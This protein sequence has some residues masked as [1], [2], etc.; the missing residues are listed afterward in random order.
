MSI[1]D[2][3]KLNSRYEAINASFVA[4]AGSD[5]SSPELQL[6]AHE[7]LKEKVLNLYRSVTGM[8]MGLVPLPDDIEELDSSVRTL[9]TRVS[10]F[11]LG[12]VSPDSTHSGVASPLTRSPDLSDL[13]ERM[14]LRAPGQKEASSIRSENDSPLKKV[15]PSERAPTADES[16]VFSPGSS[17]RSGQKKRHI[18]MGAS[19]LSSSVKPE[20]VEL[21]KSKDIATKKLL[22]AA[23]QAII[24]DYP[25]MGMFKDLPSEM[26]M[27]TQLHI[28]S[29]AVQ[30]IAGIQPSIWNQEILAAVRTSLSDIDLEY[31]EFANPA[32]DCPIEIHEALPKLL[33]PDQRA[34]LKKW[35]VQLR[36]LLIAAP[37]LIPAQMLMLATQSYYQIMKDLPYIVWSQEDPIVQISRV[38]NLVKR[39]GI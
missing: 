22:K 20:I 24:D 18:A 2:F 21:L 38:Y 11:T 13:L 27:F 26:I 34:A 6:A 16:L 4:F 31:P 12:S 39:Q 3:T 30:K 35:K 8:I 29:E 15:C 17:I 10:S 32:G 28:A 25:E 33:E 36:S 14:Q 37:A 7:E 19:S 23:L 9:R 5:F 1:S